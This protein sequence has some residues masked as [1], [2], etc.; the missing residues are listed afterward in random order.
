MNGRRIAR[1]VGLGFALLLGLDLCGAAWL[2]SEGGYWR[3]LPPFAATT[4]A[5]QRAWLERQ[6]TA[7]DGEA[8]LVGRTV[9]F[10]AQLGW[11]NRAS[12]QSSDGRASYGVAGARGPREYA[13]ERAAGTTRW[14]AF[15]DSFTHGDGLAD[16][17][18]WQHLVEQRRPGVE[19]ANFGVGG[20]GV[21][22]ALLR[23]RRDGRPLAPDVVWIGLML[24]NIGRHLN[25]Y[26]PL[27]H[28]NSPTCAAKPRFVFEGGPSTDATP[29][30]AAS[31]RAIAI[32]FDTRRGFVE[33]VADGSVIDRLAQH[34][35]WPSRR[36]QWMRHSALLSL[37]SGWA[38]YRSVDA[39]RLWSE[40][41]EARALT[42]A[43]L[44]RFHA[45]AR[46]D[47]A[48]QAAVLVFPRRAEFEQV[49]SGAERWWAGP[50][51][52]LERAGVPVLDLCD[53]W[54][55]SGC[56]AAELFQ[57][58]GHPSRR[59]AELSAAAVLAFA[60]ARF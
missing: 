19:C 4:N 1:R 18:T 33:A 52:D 42:L 22:Q 41:G 28:P 16:E 10:D 35:G 24:E 37:A 25:R 48:R 44:M 8:E 20:Y 26:R 47:G 30:S 50:M 21:D 12:S 59:A 57:P 17:E 43:L 54:A 7:G 32:P 27:Y 56:E 23:Y 58:D 11:C 49:R 14:V 5:A 45:E 29:L 3:A 46:A 13:R 38:F 60:D 36:P 2:R 6:L 40:P 15:G 34:E 9:E 31:L 39:Q 53:A 51:A 55:A